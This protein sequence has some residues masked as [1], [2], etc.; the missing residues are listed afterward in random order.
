MFGDD[1]EQTD[2][3]IVAI[4]YDFDQS[5]FVNAP[6]AAPGEQFSLTSVRQRLYRGRC[7]NNEHIDASLQSFRDARGSIEELIAEQVGL[8]N[9]TRKSVLRF[10][11]GFYKIAD[12]PKNGTKRINNKCIAP[13]S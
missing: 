9:T 5:G 11:D 12:H 4:P 3:L 6:Y 7:E 13:A 8:S 2:R 1:K 10:V